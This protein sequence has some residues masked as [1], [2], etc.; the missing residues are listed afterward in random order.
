[1]SAD[2]FMTVW[3]LFRALEAACEGTGL[4]DPTVNGLLEAA[5]DEIGPGGLCAGWH[6]V[7]AR[8]RQALVEHAEE[9]DC[10]CGSA[11]WM[12]REQF[13]RAEGPMEDE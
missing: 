9:L 8:L 13:P 3:G 1:M 4:P 10:D 7:A 5:E 2:P 6:L 12:E 11:A